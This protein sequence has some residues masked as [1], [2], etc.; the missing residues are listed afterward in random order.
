MEPEDD[1]LLV[2]D[3]TP[4]ARAAR[5]VATVA[6]VD[7]DEAVH[8]GTRFALQDYVLEGVG[9]RI[10]SAYSAQEARDL[11]ERHPETAVVLLDV[12][13]ETDRA[14]LDLVEFIRKQLGNETIRIILR[15]GQPGQAPEREVVLRYDI[16]DYKA[17]TELTADKLFTTL[18]AALRS[19][20]QLVRIGDT[21]RALKS[22]V[23]F[24]ARLMGQRSVHRLADEVLE[25]LA[26]LAG[27]P[28]GALV[29]IDEPARP[30]QGVRLLASTGIHG[31][32]GGLGAFAALP[33]E[34]G[35]DLRSLLDGPPGL[36]SAVPL[37]VAL[38][39][40]G[41]RRVAIRVDGGAGMADPVLLP[42]FMDR[43]A[44][45]FDM[46][47]LQEELRLAN[48]QLEQR[49]AQRT[50]EL[51]AA[52]RR[53]ETQY[54]RARRTAA[55]QNEV[56]GIVAHD[57]K[58]PLAVI[59]GRT[60]ILQ[61]T[62]ARLPDVAEM[63]R[64]QLERIRESA[65]RLTGMVDALIKDAMVDASE[66]P[67]RLESTDA[68]A[69][70]R[71]AVDANRPLAERKGQDIQFVAPPRLDV[72]CDH[73]RMREAVDNLVSNA[74]KYSPRDGHIAVTVSRLGDEVVIAVQDSGPG[75]QPEDY[76]RLFGRFQRLSARPTGGENSTGLG[77]FITKRIVDLHEGRLDVRSLGAGMG[78]VFTIAIRAAV[79]REVAA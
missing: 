65:R 45:A 27:E 34:L 40:A 19:H 14:G 17:K 60:E 33:E 31:G 61:E 74:V 29:A 55:F 77:L 76:P 42:L 43:V 63:T 8:E 5:R 49:V 73:E 16:N 26:E 12:V 9:L 44:A 57:L 59:M 67:M 28:S 79:G 62:L 68:V 78:S 4:E 56:L 50:G 71:E 1:F 38:S 39:T 48:E 66:L 24:T 7:D 47:L 30:S 51:M 6:V 46:L 15:T 21:N 35:E 53:L 20:D 18:T 75:L 37:R 22:M 11:L 58:N 52:N 10:L 13:M 25:C 23:E 64:G 54:A 32:A 41:G 72:V 36:R 2:V 3:D 69:L 70:V